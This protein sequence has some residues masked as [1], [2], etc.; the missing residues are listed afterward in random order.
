MT[1]DG[2]FIYSAAVLLCCCSALRLPAG[3]IYMTADGTLILRTVSRSVRSKEVENITEDYLTLEDNEQVVVDR[4]C[5]MH[6]A[7]GKRAQQY[8]VREVPCV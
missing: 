8:Q 4:M 1:S 3:R 6:V 2:V 7:S 5:C